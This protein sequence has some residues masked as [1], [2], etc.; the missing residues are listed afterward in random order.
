MSTKRTTAFK[1]RALELHLKDKLPAKEA[2]AQACK[3]HGTTP[4]GCM[5]DYATSYMWDY[6]VWF[7]QQV[8]K[9]NPEVINRQITNQ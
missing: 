5:T 2:F 8:E 3:E 9:G 1:L 4:S 7:K 6:K